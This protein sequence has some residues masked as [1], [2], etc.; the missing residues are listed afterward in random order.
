MFQDS[1][2]PRH[3]LHFLLM[4]LILAVALLKYNLKM[5]RRFNWKEGNSAM[6]EGLCECA[7]L[8]QAHNF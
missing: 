1:V 2:L 4:A 6:E 3:G 8:H 7:K 5:P